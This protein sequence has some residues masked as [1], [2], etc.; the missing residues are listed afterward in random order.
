MKVLKLLILFYFIVLSA[1]KELSF[2][3]EDLQ[4]LESTEVESPELTAPEE[5]NDK[6]SFNSLSDETNMEDEVSEKETF[7]EEEITIISENV[8][9]T[10]DTII[11]NKKVVLDMIEIK[12]FEYDLFIIADE[13]ISNHA[14]IL[15]FPK[16]AKAD[17]EQNGKPGGSISIESQIARGELKLILNGEDGGFVPVR[18]ISKRQKDRLRGKA[19]TNGR[20]AVYKL[21]CRD[22]YF[23]AAFG[24]VRNIPIGEEC[25]YECV[26]NPTRG[27]DGEDGRQGLSGHDGKDG[28]SSGSFHLKAIDLL[29]FHLADIKN[30][31][32]RGSSGGRG[33]RGGY[34]GR[35]G[36][37]GGDSK[38]LC[39]YRLSNPKRGDKG[40]T[41]PRGKRG[42]NGEK[43]T[44]CIEQIVKNSNTEFSENNSMEQSN[45]AQEKMTCY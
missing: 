42:N 19:G 1:C 44:V 21:Y 37:N 38:N 5:V 29:D 45:Q 22:I 35:A 40:K 24:I 26:A 39:K 6:A 28:G 15:N 33:S 7:S 30:I 10:E 3:N 9:L 16:D 12:T 2:T 25:W 13:F 20:S 8:E 32:G 4:S 34:G 41:G 23:P 14:T 18:D 31:P 11:Q 43:G 27:Q 36:K 17:T